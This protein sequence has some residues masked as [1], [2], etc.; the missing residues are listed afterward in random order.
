MR[1]GRWSKP[2]PV[3]AETAHFECATAAIFGGPLFAKPS[4]T[5][6]TGS[7]Y[8]TKQ[9][10]TAISNSETDAA[11][12]GVDSDRGDARD[13]WRWRLRFGAH[14]EAFADQQLREMVLYCHADLHGVAVAVRNGTEVA[15]LPKEVDRQVSLDFFEVRGHSFQD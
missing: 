14:R 4:I 8:V 12:L 10:D 5:H 6:P 7:M 1:C 9:K 11:D 13:D 2:T 3:G 15:P